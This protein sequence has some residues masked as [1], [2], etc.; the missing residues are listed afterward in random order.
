MGTLFIFLPLKRAQS[1]SMKNFKPRLIA[2]MNSYSQ[3]KS[4]GDMVFIELAKRMKN[5]DKII[6]TSFLGKKLCQ[7]KGLKGKYLITT[8]ET[9]FRNVI[10]TYLKRISKALFLKIKAKEGDVYLG[11]SDF[12]PD[13]LPIFWF[14]LKN[15]KVKWVQHVFHLIPFSRKISFFNQRISFLLIKQIADSVI[16]DNSLLRDDLIKLGFEASRIFINYPG[17]DLDYLKSVKG[18]GVD[19]YDAIFMAQLR[20][21]KGIFDL[22]KI[23]KL[24][25]QKKPNVKLGVIGGGV[26]TMVKRMQSLIESEGLKRN[27]DLLGYLE[28]DDAFAIIKSSKV[29]VF[30][31]KEEGFGLASL[32]A[33][34]LGLPVIAWDLPVY[35]EV[36]PRGMIKVKMKNMRR[37][38]DEVLKLLA[39]K[40]NYQRLSKA[41]IDN[42]SRYDWDQAAKR[43]FQIINS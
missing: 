34:A 12:L 17:I 20:S 25:C 23:W 40:K 33:Q 9:E 41:A 8:K 5:Y 16:V 13:V 38:A 7:K 1:L 3:G 4:G 2:L 42:A 6:I 28:D 24:I 29:F 21:S 36:F 43:E 37:F 31:S 19:G 15:R 26:E 22:I 11:T 14:K 30:P 39:N 35:K 18:K 10:L 27:I 32:E